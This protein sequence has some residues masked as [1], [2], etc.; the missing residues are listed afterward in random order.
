[1]KSAA[2]EKEPVIDPHKRGAS[3][4]VR[5]LVLTVL[6]V[7]LGEL[8]IFAP[9]VSRYRVALLNERIGAA[10]LALT[11]VEFARAELTFEEKRS[12]MSLAGVRGMTRWRAGE[13]PLTIG[14]DMPPM[15]DRAFDLRA[16][17]PLS[18]IFDALSEIAPHRHD[19]IAV[20]GY[21]PDTPDTV[22]EVVLDE[23]TICHPVI[24]Y[25]VQVLI[26][27][28]FLSVTTAALL[29][30]SLQWLVVGPMRRLSAAMLAFRNNPRA[31]A[32]AVE[33]PARRADEVGVAERSLLAMQGDLRTL[34]REQDRLADVGFAVTKVTHDL[35]NM[36]TAVML[37]SDRLEQAAADPEV[38]KVT[39][40]LVK[41]LERAVRLCTSTVRYA[42]GDEAPR[43]AVATHPAAEAV[44]V[45]AEA[46]GGV[47]GLA[48]RMGDAAALG[49]SAADQAVVAFDADALHRVGNNLAVNAQEAGATEIA[50]NAAIQGD[51]LRI[52]V[53]D[54]GPGLPEKARAHLF[55]PFRGSARSGGAGL[56]LPTAREVMVAHG[57]G[58]DLADSTT[59]GA[60]FEITLPLSTVQD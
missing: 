3:L 51:V 44:A 18:L 45:L 32:R 26:V 52:T 50:L 8:L 35:K 19:V 56:G 57:G 31:E 15:I 39:S 41:A 48:V 10:H 58:L 49:G 43:L 60:V 38:K 17:G 14:P 9:S 29:Y 13:P 4:S 33:L 16:A 27:S 5:L 2:M 53:A 21:V 1:M 25:G 55:E 36:L 22:I 23:Q 12:L 59:S 42:A 37:E 24:E 30:A 34:L 11:G 40:G 54:N 7:M 46:C 6:F 28:V 20:T 47:P